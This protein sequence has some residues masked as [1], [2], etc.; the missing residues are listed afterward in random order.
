M[1]AIAWSKVTLIIRTAGTGDIAAGTLNGR[2]EMAT[3]LINLPDPVSHRMELVAEP[4]QVKG[5]PPGFQVTSWIELN[6]AQH[7]RLTKDPVDGDIE[8]AQ[9]LAANDG[10]FRYDYVRLGCTFCPQN[11]E[12]FE[13]AWL[14]VTLKPDEAQCKE[15]PTSWSIFPLEDHDKIERSASAKIG[16]SV[17]IL[18]AEVN[19]SSKGEIKLYNVRGYREGGPDPYWEMY[20][21]EANTLD[22]ALRFHM[23]VRSASASPTVGE[24]RLEAVI[25]NRTFVVFRNKRPFDQSPSSTFRLPVS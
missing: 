5:S 11:G 18:S 20:S 12:R 6:D 8:L 21:N 25:S 23:V 15:P 3:A 9:F 1:A 10:T 13:K 7:I 17:K 24:V 19:A 22:G 14:T 4:R 16:A 2:T